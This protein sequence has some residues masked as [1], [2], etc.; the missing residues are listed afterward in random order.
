M[1]SNVPD[2]F[3]TLCRSLNLADSDP[4][5]LFQFYGDASGNSDAVTVGGYVSTLEKWEIFKRLWNAELGKEQVDFFRRSQMEPPFHGA[6][7]DLGWTV[8][9]QIPVLH[10]LHRIIKNTTMKGAAKSVRMRAFSQLMPRKVKQKYGGAYG[11]CLLL[12]LVDIGLWARSRGDWVSYIFEAGDKGRHE[13]EKCI[14]QMY[15]DP[16]T[17]ETFR[18][19]NWSFVPKVG[20]LAAVQ[21]QSADFI[22][23]EA[24]KA[25]EN[26]LTG[27]ERKPRKSMLDL[28]RPKV[29]YFNLWTDEA[30]SRWLARIAECNGNVLDSLITTDPLS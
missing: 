5:A 11:W 20:P 2:V 12:N 24:Y 3:T 1:M 7:A 27:S 25:I 8:R 28:I 6:F 10:R 22:A 9:H 16:V 15:D 23:F 18:I 4:V 17:R 14:G 19:A 29:D 26:Y 21:L 30:L 13:I